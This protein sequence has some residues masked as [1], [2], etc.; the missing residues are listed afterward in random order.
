MALVLETAARTALADAIAASV[1]NGT[2]ETGGKLVIETTADVEVS[3]HRFV[4]PAFGGGAVA[5]VLTLDSVPI[6]DTSAAGGT[7]AQ[8]SV[9]DRDNT[10]L[11]EGVVAVTGQDLDLSSLSVGVGDTVSLTAFTVT[12][13][14]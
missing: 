13:P 11:W 4:D 8:Y 2:T 6:D 1:D 10:K 5:G 7:A 3:L 9:F 12:Q 14:A